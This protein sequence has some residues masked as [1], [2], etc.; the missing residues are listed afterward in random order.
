MASSE[1]LAGFGM[2]GRELLFGQSLPPA[3][4]LPAS[5]KPEICIA[6]N[7]D[8]YVKTRIYFD[9]SCILII[10]ARGLLLKFILSHSVLSLF[11]IDQSFSS[12]VR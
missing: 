11:F 5:L 6:A 9:S 8:R 3:F 4:R 1:R 7:S 2:D 10:L 12:H